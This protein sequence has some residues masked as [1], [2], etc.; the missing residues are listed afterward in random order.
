MLSHERLPSPINLQ[1]WRKERRVKTGFSS[2]REERSAWD[3]LTFFHENCCETGY[4]NGC[5]SSILPFLSLNRHWSLIINHY[6]SLLLYA[7]SYR[8]FRTCLLRRC[9]VK[10][11]V[12]TRQQELMLRGDW[13]KAFLFY[14]TFLSTGKLMCMNRVNHAYTMNSF[15]SV[16]LPIQPYIFYQK[17]NLDCNVMCFFLQKKIRQSQV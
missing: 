12:R 4:E 6:V 14:F 13:K 3:W 9:R 8:V 7:T 1:P 17:L 11:E 10:D 15:S 16:S 5:G 2:L